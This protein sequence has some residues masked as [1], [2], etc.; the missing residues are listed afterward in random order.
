MSKPI[1]VYV[2]RSADSHYVHHSEHFPSIK[3]VKKSAI[4]Y[5]FGFGGRS[6]TFKFPRNYT[7]EVFRLHFIPEYR[8]SR[9]R[10]YKIGLKPSRR[11]SEPERLILSRWDVFPEDLRFNVEVKGSE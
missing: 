6:S 3:S 5:A 4:A 8:L 2:L 1:Y 9:V 11:L 10:K 7:I